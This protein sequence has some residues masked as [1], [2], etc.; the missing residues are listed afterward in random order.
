MLNVPTIA[1]KHLNVIHNHYFLAIYVDGKKHLPYLH[2]Y[3][4]LHQ[5]N[6]F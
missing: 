5:Y 4:L 1:V 2:N 3:T 6:T